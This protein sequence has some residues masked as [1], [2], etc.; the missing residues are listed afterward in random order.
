MPATFRFFPPKAKATHNPILVANSLLLPRSALVPVDPKTRE[1]KFDGATN[2]NPAFGPVN[3]IGMSS[4]IDVGGY[5]NSGYG[6]R[7]YGESVERKSKF[8]LSKNERILFEDLEE[9]MPEFIYS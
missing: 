4:G 7:P 6:A 1:R 3:A 5:G 2:K 8:H 9:R